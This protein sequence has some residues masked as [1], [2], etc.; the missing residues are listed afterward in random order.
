[1]ALPCAI[2]FE[3]LLLPL[4]IVLLIVTGD[5]SIG[6][7]FACDLG[8]RAELLW[9]EPGKVIASAPACRALIGQQSPFALPAAKGLRRDAKRFGSLM[10]WYELARHDRSED[11]T[12][13]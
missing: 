2:Q 3:H 9:L 8:L 13:E 11:H 6:N 10:D 7:R 4:Q 5:A 1:P 12:S